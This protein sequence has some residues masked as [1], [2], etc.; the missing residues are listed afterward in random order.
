MLQLLVA[1]DVAF[2]N[3]SP[4]WRRSRPPLSV[5]FSLR[6]PS[7]HAA[8]LLSADV[9]RARRAARYGRRA[10]QGLEKIMCAPSAAALCALS[11]T[12]GG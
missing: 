5:D 12:R 7:T 9:A 8:A 3:A 4:A 1:S 6:W 11:S 10:A 2:A